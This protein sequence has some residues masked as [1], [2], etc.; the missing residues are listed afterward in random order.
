MTSI[1]RHA[2]LVL[3]AAFLI[4]PNAACANK[5]AQ[6]VLAQ[7]LPQETIIIET[8]EGQDHSFDVEIAI[9]PE[10]QSRGLMFRSQM[11]DNKGMLFVFDEEDDRMFWMRDTLIPLDMLFIGKDG[12]IRHIHHNAKPLDETHITSDKPAMAVLEIN[13]TLAGQLGIKEGDKIIHPA[14]RNAPIP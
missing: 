7:P 1:L 9:K 5:Q 8:A 10:D 4:F 3:S 6:P 12:V 2:C 14:F 13:G 11:A